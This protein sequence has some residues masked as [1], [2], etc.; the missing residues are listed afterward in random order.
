MAYQNQIDRFDIERGDVLSLTREDVTRLA[1]YWEISH[2]ILREL[3]TWFLGGPDKP[4]EDPRDDMH[5]RALKEHQRANAARRYDYLVAQRE[6]KMGKGK[7][8][9][10][11]RITTDTSKEE[12]E[13]EAKVKISV[14]DKSSLRADASTPASA[15]DAPGVGSSSPE[16]LR[17]AHWRTSDDTEVE[18]C[19]I[20]TEAEFRDEPMRYLVEWFGNEYEPELAR[21]TYRKYLREL[22]PDAFFPIAWRYFKEGVEL[23]S[24]EAIARCKYNKA[25]RSKVPN[26]D[27]LKGEARRGAIKTFEETKEGRYASNEKD[28]CSS[29]NHDFNGRVLVARLK[30][31]KLAMGLG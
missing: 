25:L 5:L 11:P 20:C 26:F 21:N 14:S 18:W 1:D 19:N 9:G 4:M 7:N 8:H 10:Q 3:F 24:R 22:G 23:S 28:R 6:R 15:A 2:P 13:E 27:Q 31:K 16:P 12:E 17:Y 30:E 29:E